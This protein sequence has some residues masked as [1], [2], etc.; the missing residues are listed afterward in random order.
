MDTIERPP[1]PDYRAPDGSEIRLLP[2]TPRGGL[3]CCSLAPGRATRPVKHRSV[4]EVW[5]CVSGRGQ[6]W[7]KY[8]QT[9]SVVD[10]KPGI[11]CLIPFQTEFQ[12]R[13]IG[14]SDDAGVVEEQLELVIA[15][16]PGWPGPEEA[17]PV[18]TGKWPPSA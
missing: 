5:Y 9:E 8:G 13:S 2:S 4:E 15:T 18:D 17:V 10:L 14:G 11:S 7:R 1:A 3:S 12:F 6:L 16:F